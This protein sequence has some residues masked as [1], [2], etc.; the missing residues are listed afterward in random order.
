MAIA[1]GGMLAES[2]ALRGEDRGDRSMGD[3]ILFTPIRAGALQLPNRI[4]MAR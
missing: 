2:S 4:V 3:E 1:G